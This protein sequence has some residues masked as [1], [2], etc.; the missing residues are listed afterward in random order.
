VSQISQY[1]KT[2]IAVTVAFI[3]NGSVVG[4]FYARIADIK[5]QLQISNSALGFALLFFAVG[6]LIGLGFL[7]ASAQIEA[8]HP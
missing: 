4:S 1:S 2:R 6:V 8:A 5:S 7:V 3:I